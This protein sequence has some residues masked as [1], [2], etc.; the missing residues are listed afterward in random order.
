MRRSAGVRARSR[1]WTISLTASAVALVL[2]CCAAARA[3]CIGDCDGNGEVTVNEIITEVNIALTTA[4]VFT[5]PAGDSNGDGVITIDELVASDVNLLNGCGAPPP[6]P[7]ASGPVSIQVGS[8]TGAPGEQVAVA[9]TLET[10][11]L[12]VVA[13]TQNDIVFDPLNASIAPTSNGPP[14]C[15]VN[16]AINKN[17]AFGFLP[18]GCA[19]AQCTAVRALVFA[20]SNTDPIPDGATLYTCNVAISASAASGAIPLT[21]T[22][23]IAADPGGSRLSNVSGIDGMITVSALPTATPVAPTSTAPAGTATITPTSSAG[24]PTSPPFATPTFPFVTPTPRVATPTPS[25]QSGPFLCTA[26][27]NDGK[28]CLSDSDCPGGACVIAQGVCNG[29]TDDGLPCDCA[30]GNCATQLVC[31][32]DASMGTCDAGSATG[33]CC[34]T[35]DNCTGNLPC[36]GSQKVCLGGDDKGFACLNDRQCGGSTCVSTGLFCVG[37]DFDGFSCVDD[38]DCSGG[39]SCHAAVETLDTP[40]PF[41]TFA[42][43]SPTSVIP[44]GLAGDANCDG[45]ITAADLPAAVA[46]TGVGSTCPGADVDGD[47]AITAADVSALPPKIFD[48]VEQGLNA[49]AAGDF[50]TAQLRFCAAAAGSADARAPL[51]C[52]LLSLA[53]TMIDDGQLRSLASRGGVQMQGDSQ[54]VCQVHVTVPHDV[55]L[56]APRSG[57]IITTVS[58][59][60]A[61][62]IDAAIADLQGISPSVRIRFDLRTLPACLQSSLDNR[63]SALPQVLEI[64]QGDVLALT[65]GLQFARATAEILS[66][67]DLDVD[68]HSAAGMTPQ[69]I[70][71][72]APSLLT[73]PSV[74]ALTSARGF[75]DAALASASQ[76]ITSI[77]GETDDQSDDLLVIEPD[78]VAGAQRTQQIL[79]LI[80]KALHQEVTLSPDVG[81]MPPQRLNLDLFFSG[82]FASLRTF[83]PAFN[84]TGG[85]DFGAFP[86]P[87]FGGTALDFTQ[88]DI[89]H[90]LNRSNN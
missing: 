23:A 10:M 89:D 48:A 21:I 4:H 88:P 28:D 46:A 69:A 26:G 43:P 58:A 39:G 41:P 54:D 87:T 33:D 71:D 6:T 36:V 30:G 75:V 82:Q 86:D 9:V 31:S 20:L 55:P 59:V 38:A 81:V 49:V 64:D 66:A 51:G 11:G 60:L 80:R 35:A 8:A 62:A 83:L 77:L 67:Y 65:A 5:C 74:D 78:D 73:S 90:I 17:A 45:R 85:F 47:G 44:M 70:L 57:E 68:L 14:D 56:G 25:A 79:A 15:V 27:S 12:A 2:S 76:S 1:L 19:G 29:G 3:E 72:A 24:E 52:A 63:R 61:P 40:T 84:D 32:S 22:G 53:V 50:A 37:G 16:G 7:V 18:A 42:F 34:S 13:G